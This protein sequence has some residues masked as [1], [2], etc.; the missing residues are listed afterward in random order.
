MTEK[1]F[2]RLSVWITNPARK[3][4]MEVNMKLLTIA[5]TAIQ[6]RLPPGKIR[7]FI[8]NDKTFPG[9][10]F[11]KKTIRVDAEKLDGWWESKTTTRPVNA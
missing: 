11:S 3:G 6:L 9:Y 1:P 7:D 10:I 5:E 8:K 2:L 4:K